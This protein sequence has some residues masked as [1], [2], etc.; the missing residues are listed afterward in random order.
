MSQRGLLLNPSALKLSEHQVDEELRATDQRILDAAHAVGFEHTD[1]FPNSRDQV[2]KFLFG[3]LGLK[4]KKHTT[5]RARPSVDQES[6]TRVLRTLRKQDEHHRHVLHDLFHRTRLFTIL[7]RYLRS[8]EPEDDG[9]VRPIVKMNHVKTWRLAYARPALQQWPE[10]CRHIFVAAPGHVF[11]HA[12]YRQLEARLLAYYSLDE[13]S[14][15]VF[16]TG[17]DPHEANARDLFHLS[18]AE[19]DALENPAPFRNYSKAWLY[20]QVYG[21]SAISGDKKLYC[22]CPRCAARMPSTVDLSPRA[23]MLA[24][25][26]WHARHPTVRRWQATVAKEVRAN[27]RFPLLMGGY[28]YISAPW[29]RDLDRE[30]RNIPM[31]S[32]AARLMIRAQNALH[33]QGAPIVLQH[34]DSFLLE[35]PEAEVEHWSETLHATMEQPVEIEGRQVSFP[36]ELKQGRDWGHLLSSALPQNRTRQ[37]G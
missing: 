5:K 30:L 11:L 19:W 9:R 17:G 13:S 7:S 20:R 23:A 26:R 27:H 28:R 21:G 15:R 37:A 31:Q 29:S 6:L 16:E 2:A 22:P 36:I 25:E 24:E 35:V 34:H 4:P 10:E 12:D 3:A 32:G 1:K 33:A 8:L 18:Q 14:I